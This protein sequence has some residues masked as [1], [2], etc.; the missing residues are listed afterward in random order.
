MPMYFCAAGS[1][2]SSSFITSCT[3]PTFTSSGRA[4]TKSP[5]SSQRLSTKGLQYAMPNGRW[6]APSV[7]SASKSSSHPNHLPIYPTKACGGARSIHF[8]ALCLSSMTQMLDCH[9]GRLTLAMDMSCFINGPSTQ[10]FPVVTKLLPSYNFSALDMHYHISK[11]GPD[12]A[13]QMG[14]S[15]ALLGG[16]RFGCQSKST[17]HRMSR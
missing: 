12:C 17:S 9:M 4:S 6:S 2:S 3:N 8:S 1:T 5:T 7:T 10:S 11:S 15:P 13:Y 16:R 14:R